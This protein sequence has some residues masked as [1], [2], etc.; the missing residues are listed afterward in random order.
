M[1]KQRLVKEELAAATPTAGAPSEA[2]EQAAAAVLA[3]G[4]MVA[5]TPAEPHCPEAP[6]S[7][8][9]ASCDAQMVQEQLRDLQAYKGAYES[10]EAKCQ[11]FRERI[12]EMEV[13]ITAQQAKHAHLAGLA[14]EARTVFFAAMQALAQGSPNGSVG[15]Q[16]SWR[17]VVCSLMAVVKPICLY[18]D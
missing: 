17:A 16:V 4:C 6:T 12:V 14:R 3:M 5:S 7:H 10:S 15:E 1:A 13:G 2:G 8:A 9:G 18:E 11:S